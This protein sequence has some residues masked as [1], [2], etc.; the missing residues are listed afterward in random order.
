MV[1]AKNEKKKIIGTGRIPRQEFVELNLANQV[2]EVYLRP[3]KLDKDDRSHVVDVK[4]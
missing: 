2:Q 3:Y 1:S 4:V